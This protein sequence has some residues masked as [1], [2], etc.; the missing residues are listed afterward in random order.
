MMLQVKVG[1]FGQSRRAKLSAI[2]KNCKIRSDGVNIKSHVRCTLCI[3]RSS[4]RRIRAFA[5]LYLKRVYG[6]TDIVMHEGEQL[7]ANGK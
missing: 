7:E 1:Y 6:A 4:E 3:L 5:L 2:W